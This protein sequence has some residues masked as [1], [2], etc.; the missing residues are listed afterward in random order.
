MAEEVLDVAVY[1][2]RVRWTNTLR[3]PSLGAP[4][5]ALLDLDSGTVGVVAVKGAPL[6]CMPKGGVEGVEAP[7]GAYRGGADVGCISPAGR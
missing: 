7:K 1:I 2:R 5:Q 4:D 6:A 3:G